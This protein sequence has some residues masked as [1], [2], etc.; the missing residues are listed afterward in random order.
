MKEKRGLRSS[1]AGQGSLD[2][3]EAF[4][5]K[6]TLQRRLSLYGKRRGFNTFWPLSPPF[7]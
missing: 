4:K 5:G 2:Q 7:C 3:G 6:M 1:S